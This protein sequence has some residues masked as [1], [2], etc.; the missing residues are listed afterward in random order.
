MP[1]PGDLVERERV[2]SADEIKALW[3][4]TE[5]LQAPF[6]QYVRVLLLTAQ[7]RSEVSGM[8]WAEIAGGN[9]LIPGSRVKNGKRF[10]SYRAAHG[11]RPR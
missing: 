6:R 3:A 1:R 9:W 2:L 10:G 4:A 11:S 8:R 5:K 7:R